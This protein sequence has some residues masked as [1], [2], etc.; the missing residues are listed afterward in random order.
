MKPNTRSEQFLARAAGNSGE[1]LTPLTRLEHFLKDIADAQGGGGGSVTS[2]N[3]QTGAVVLTASDVGAAAVETVVEVEG[4]TPTIT[5]AANTVYNCGELTSLTISN[6]PATGKY[7]IIFYS[8]AT[9]TTTVGI[10]N[11]AADAN[12]RYEIKVKDNYA[13]YEW[14]PYTPT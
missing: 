13:T 7:T 8:G 6:P 2:V 1:D 9:P 11:F 12:K 5:P 10:E 14:W 4:A 3:G